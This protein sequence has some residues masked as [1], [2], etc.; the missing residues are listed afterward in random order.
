MNDDA[1]LA[2]LYET[3]AKQDLNWHFP[4]TDCDHAFMIAEQHII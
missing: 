1:K 2:A 3:I 4:I